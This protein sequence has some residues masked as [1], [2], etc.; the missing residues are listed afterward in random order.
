M[1][2][3]TIGKYA[4]GELRSNDTIVD[5]SNGYYEQFYKWEDGTKITLRQATVFKNKD[6]SKLLGITVHSWD[7]VCMVSKTSFYEI[8]TTKKDI[9]VI[10]TRALMPP[11][12]FKDFLKDTSSVPNLIANLEELET[13]ELDKYDN[14]ESFVKENNLFDIKYSMPQI[15]MSLTAN[16]DVC[17]YYLDMDEWNWLKAKHFKE[18]VLKYN[19]DLKRFEKLPKKE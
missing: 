15:G 4:E 12:T 6:N 1:K 17:D 8:G 3:D 18:V 2:E 7:F 11:L 13:T 5:L 10:D 9:K 16:V 19:N 14:F